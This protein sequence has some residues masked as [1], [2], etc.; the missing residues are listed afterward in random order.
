[1]EE[2][3]EFSGVTFVPVREFELPNFASQISLSC[4]EYAR[5]TKT[6]KLEKNDIQ[7]VDAVRHFAKNLIR[8]LNL[9]ELIFVIVTVINIGALCVFAIFI[10]HQRVISS[11][12]NG[13]FC[14][15]V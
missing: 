5:N 6:A 10:T 8:V 9:L 3:F 13:I 14:F 15:A 4:L 2:A 7:F 12:T 11:E 1:V